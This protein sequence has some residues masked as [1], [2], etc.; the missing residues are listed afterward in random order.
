M[1]SMRIDELV[2]E[3]ERVLPEDD[4]LAYTYGSSDPPKENRACNKWVGRGLE[5]IIQVL[6]ATRENN[7]STT[8]LLI[9]QHRYVINLVR[10]HAAVSPPPPSPPRE[11]SLDVAR[12]PPAS[13]EVR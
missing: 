10:A 12:V 7:F 5:G 1:R 4:L 8:G 9:Q 3:N 2:W 11:V 13:S 6:W